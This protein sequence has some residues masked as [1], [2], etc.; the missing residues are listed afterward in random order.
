MDDVHQVRQYVPSVPI[1]VTLPSGA[2]DADAALE[3]GATDVI[4]G[5]VTPRIIRRRLEMIEAFAATRSPRQEAPP[6][7]NLLGFPMPDLRSADSGRLDAQ[8]VADY[9]GIP[10]RRLA[11]GVGLPY[12]G[13]HKTPDAYRVQAPLAPVARVLELAREALGSREAVRMWLNRSLRE[14]EPA[15]GDARGRSRSRGNPAG[16]RTRRHPG[17]NSSRIPPHA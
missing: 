8:K 13:V 2:D 3:S 10:L 16:K 1:L 17:L 9:M 12:A 7:A 15:R 6:A 5:A 11:G 14:R 4:Q